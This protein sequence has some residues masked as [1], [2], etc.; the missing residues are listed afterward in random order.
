MREFTGYEVILS[1]K[2]RGGA[3]L[4]SLAVLIVALGFTAYIGAHRNVFSGATSQYTAL[5]NSAN[6]LRRGAAVM[7]S[8]VTVGEVNDISID[9]DTDLAKVVFSIDKT[10][11]LTVDAT[12]AI[13]APDMTSDN[14]LMVNPGHAASR[15]KPFEIITSTTDQ[16]SLEQ[17]VSDYIF[18]GHLQ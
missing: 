14:A 13:I 1:Q 16:L 9:K 17:Q 3:A 8:G 11:P 12:I 6:G 10:L 4:A 5:F 15:L 18:G 2:S 7:V